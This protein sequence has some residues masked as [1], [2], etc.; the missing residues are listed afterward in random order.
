MN[1][2]NYEKYDTV[3]NES[4]NMQQRLKCSALYWVQSQ[5]VKIGV[6]RHFE[7]VKPLEC[8]VEA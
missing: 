2:K 4:G 3:T 1:E 8:W 6:V 5:S 7:T